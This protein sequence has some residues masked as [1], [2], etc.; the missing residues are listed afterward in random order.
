MSRIRRKATYLGIITILLAMLAAQFGVRAWVAQ[1]QSLPGSGSRTFPET[2][3]TVTGI[4]LEYWNKNGGLPQQGFPISQLMNEVSDLDGKTYTVQYFERAEFEYHPEN[5]PPYDV[6]LSQLG[7]FQYKQKYPNVAP[8]QLPNNSPGSQLFP[9]TSKHVGGKFLEY[10]RS[11][12]GLP[13]QGFPISEEFTE[14]SDLDGKTYTVQYFERAVF[15]MHSE[16]SPPYNVLLSQ[17]GTFQYKTRYASGSTPSPSP[18]PSQAIEGLFDVGGYKLYISCAGEGSP[19]VLME[20]GLGTATSTWS[21]VLSDLRKLS[22]VCVYDRANVG[23]SERGP[24]PRTSEQVVKELRALL[25]SANVPT[26]YVLVA[27]SHG[28]LH[29]QLFASK[30]RSEVVGMV[31]IDA[32]PYDIDERYEA[33]ITPQQ[34][35]E[36]RDLIEQNREG[37]TYDAV[38]AS[39]AQVRAAGPLPEV[40]LLVLAHGRTLQYPAGWPVE[41]VERAW[42]EGQEGL[43][44]RSPKGRLIV[45]QNSGHFIH[46]DEPQLVINSVREVLQTAR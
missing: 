42:R 2:G 21:S 14:K 27:H 46:Q 43:A 33:V 22:K 25:A 23:R 11:H 38:T 7:T 13:Q 3:K 5:K 4:F 36:R 29:A 16:N 45:A 31:M 24:A 20:A 28:G 41:A 26:P 15:E 19:T 35:Q 34:A 30:Y 6:L 17:L 39:Y 40:P 8:N 18:P 44:E 37:V 1:A 32:T 9:E 10:W 12:G